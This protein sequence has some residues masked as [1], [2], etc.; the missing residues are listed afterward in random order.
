M[1]IPDLPLEVI[2]V[3][4]QFLAGDHAFASLAALYSA[5]HA[6]QE[7]TSSILHETAFL[8]TGDKVPAYLQDESE[9]GKKRREYIKSVSLT[10]ERRPRPLTEISYLDFVSATVKP[11]R[12]RP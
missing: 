5:S 6:L 12:E 4:G 9:D 3:I 7:E 11:S 10:V 8:D 1:S 2:G